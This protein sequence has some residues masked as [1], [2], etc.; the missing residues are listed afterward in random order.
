MQRDAVRDYGKA[1][2]LAAQRRGGWLDPLWVSPVMVYSVH[3]TLCN[4]GVTVVA[5]ERPE[6]PVVTTACVSQSSIKTGEMHVQKGQHF[7]H[8]AGTLAPQVHAALPRVCCFMVWVG[9][10][11]TFLCLGRSCALA[12]GWGAARVAL[13]WLA[14]RQC[15]CGSQ[16]HVLV[17]ARWTGEET[18]LMIFWALLWHLLSVSRF[19]W[20]GLFKAWWMG[21]RASSKCLR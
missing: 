6:T 4:F 17:A 1:H 5:G 8:H 11:P 16:E 13:L 10:P 18:Y 12:H 3:L 9:A 14:P 21:S 19:S 20:L 7:G 15:P 2:V